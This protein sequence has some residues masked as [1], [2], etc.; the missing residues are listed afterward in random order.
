M[1]L[2]GETARTV[3]TRLIFGRAEGGPVV[4]PRRWLRQAAGRRALR[5]SLARLTVGYALRRGGAQAQLL[6]D[7]A[8]AAL[9]T[10]ALWDPAVRAVSDWRLSGVSA[11]WPVALLERLDGGELPS[12]APVTAAD[13][14]LFHALAERLDRAADASERELAAEAAAASPLSALLWLDRDGAA[15]AL[16][17]LGPF[18]EAHWLVPFLAD[19]LCRRWLAADA[20]RGMLLRERESVLNERLADACAGLYNAWLAAERYEHLRLF[21]SLLARVMTHW[22]GVDGV[23][24]AARRG[25]W[26]GWTTARRE[27]FEAGLGRVFAVGPALAETA[28]HLRGLGW[29][30]TPA[31]EAFLGAY[32]REYEPLADSVCVLYNE[33]CR[34]V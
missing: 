21:V 23:L 3:L 2:T 13:L 15:P 34:L 16:E 18:H 19:H 12:L 29:Q 27:T 6:F 26:D 10:R 30:R 22:G 9:G 32:S 11:A 31:Q 1:R 17:P 24:H 8:G 14:L 20:R 4:E 28:A 7:D 33:L 25:R 5:D